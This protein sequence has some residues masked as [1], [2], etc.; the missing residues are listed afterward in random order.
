M[1]DPVHSLNEDVEENIL[2]DPK[3]AYFTQNKMS[4]GY[5]E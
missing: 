4:F 3:S 1:N 5:P 2:I